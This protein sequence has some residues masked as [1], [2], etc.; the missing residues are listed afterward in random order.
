MVRAEHDRSVERGDSRPATFYVEHDKERFEFTS[1]KAAADYF[2]GCMLDEMCG[3][4]IKLIDTDG[5]TVVGIVDWDGQFGL[6]KVD[7]DV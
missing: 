7:W 2:H 6:E 5:A 3:N 4:P 1:L